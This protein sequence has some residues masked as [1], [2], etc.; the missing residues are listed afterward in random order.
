MSKGLTR[1]DC[2]CD[3]DVMILIWARGDRPCGIHL[4]YDSALRLFTQTRGDRP[5]KYM[6]LA[7]PSSMYFRGVS[8][9]YS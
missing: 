7:S 2:P 1:G 5:C 9:I 3:G 6:D 8:C 4:I